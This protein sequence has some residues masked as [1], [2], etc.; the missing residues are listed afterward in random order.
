MKAV[1]FSANDYFR[2]HLKDKQ[3]NI[4]TPARQGLAGALTG[5]VQLV[6]TVPMELLKIQLQDA[7]RVARM[8]TQSTGQA[9]LHKMSALKIAADLIRSKGLFGLYKGTIPAMCRDVPFC[10]I[11]FPLVEKLQSL[12]PRKTD[13]SGDAKFYWS[14]GCGLAAA[15]FTAWFVTPADIMKTRIQTIHKGAAGDKVYSSI[16]DAF[17]DILKTEGP[18]AFYKGGA[19]RILVIAPSYAVIQSLYYLGVA[20]WLL[21][22]EKDTKIIKK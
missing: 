18:R 2:Y 19:C 11:Y 7:G 5:V 10:A 9:P 17:L 3:T 15:S 14:F 20:E 1:R 13:G 6:V 16:F 12:G 21:G 22:I 4:L 8:G